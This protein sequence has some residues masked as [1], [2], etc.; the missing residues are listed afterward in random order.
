MALQLVEL[1]VRVCV[2]RGLQSGTVWVNTWNQFD[3]A[4]PFGGYKLSG[5]GR[6]HGEE[7]LNHYTQ[8][9]PPLPAPKNK[10][11]LTSSGFSFYLY[12]PPPSLPLTCVLQLVASTCQASTIPS[13]S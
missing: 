13:S 4:V 9:P 3:A 2:C 10:D 12:C 11:P 7:V 8:V 5:I 6:E 1:F